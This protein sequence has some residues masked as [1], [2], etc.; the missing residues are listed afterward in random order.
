MKRSLTDLKYLRA[1]IYWYCSRTYLSV[2][3]LRITEIFRIYL[4]QCLELYRASGQEY[5]MRDYWHDLTHGNN[6]SKIAALQET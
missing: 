2:E 6:I 4:N 3:T 1:L 5:R